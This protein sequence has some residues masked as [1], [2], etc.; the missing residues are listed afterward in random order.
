[1]ESAAA[2]PRHKQKRMAFME[3]TPADWDEAS[4][5]ID[6]RGVHITLVFCRGGSRP[7]PPPR[8]ASNL[9][10][11]AQG[12]AHLT[13]AG[14]EASGAEAKESSRG[15][16]RRQKEDKVFIFIRLHPGATIQGW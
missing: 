12:T 7:A 6:P 16:A 8:G 5:R 2:A 14:L 4:S 10:N 1:M 9:A 13:T 3:S 11:E 15:A